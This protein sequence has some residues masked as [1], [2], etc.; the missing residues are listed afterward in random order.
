MGSAT[1]PDLHID[2]PLSNLAVMA[3]ST[4][5]EDF[6]A[7]DVF[8]TQSVGKQSDK[9]FTITKDAFLRVPDTKR[10]PGTAANR[11][12][13]DVSSDSYFAQNF[14]LANEIP[15]EDISNSDKPV[16]LRENASLLVQTNL[17]RDWEVRVADKVTSISNVGSGVVL[18]APDKWSN[19]GSDPIAQVDSGHAFIRRQ[20]GG[21]RANTMIID[22]D[23]LVEVRR[24]PLILDMFKYTSG[25]LLT[26][27]F[28]KEVFKVD[29]IL[30]GRGSKEN[31]IEGATSSITNI[32][33]NNVVLARITPAMGL[34]TATFGLSFRWKPAGIPTDMQVKRSV[35]ND[36]GSQHVEIVET[37]MY[38]DEKIIAKDLA[39]ALT[40]TL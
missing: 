11:V 9:Y 22:E 37:G 15:L 24:H 34:Q 16:R 30:V 13:F 32:W 36:A 19:A 12:M 2:V 14:A 26:D 38:Q 35:L 21:L 23:T 1:G 18:G 39:Y 6:I 5:V 28:L 4:G 3:F 8:P 7:M 10:A 29:R 31:A 25:G 33:G 17:R 40:G 20:S 27:D